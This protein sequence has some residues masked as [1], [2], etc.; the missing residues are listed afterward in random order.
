MPMRLQKREIL[1]SDELRLR[2]DSSRNLK[3]PY[4][5]NEFA[6][7]GHC[8]G[9][10]G[11][12]PMRILPKR[13]SSRMGGSRLCVGRVRLGCP[14]PRYA[15]KEYFCVCEK[16]PYRHGSRGQ[17]LDP[18]SGRFSILTKHGERCATL[19]LLM[20]TSPEFGSFSFTRWPMHSCVRSSS[21]ADI[22][23][24]VSVSVCIVG[25]P[26]NIAVPF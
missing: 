11:S 19:L 22:Q 7:C 18:L 15:A 14:H 6:K 17:K 16:R 23:Q 20:G 5:W 4:W 12:S 2:K 1:S 25:D 9:L 13:P 8:S 21:I 24:R 3:I 10:P 26:M